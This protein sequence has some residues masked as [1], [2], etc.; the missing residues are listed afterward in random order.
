[1][2]KSAPFETHSKRYDEWYVRHQA[3]YLSELLAVRVLLPWKGQG[4]EVGVGSGRFAAPL[5]VKTG[6]DPA[7][8]M[9]DLAEARGVKVIKGIAEI[10]PFEDN[11]FDYVLMNIVLSFLDDT[12]AAL[13]EIRRVLKPNGVLVIGFLDHGSKSGR[14]YLDRHAH[15]LFFREANFFSSTDVEHL[16]TD[17]GFHDLV[18]VQTLFD[19]PEGISE[20]EPVRAGH[21]KGAFVVVKA[22]SG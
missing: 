19:P 8:P 7:R 11:S 9:L 2:A 3:A 22:I 10:L 6:I 13:A 21:G 20:I 17:A 12:R 1:M 5:G 16:L 4:L 14:S 18:W 15:R